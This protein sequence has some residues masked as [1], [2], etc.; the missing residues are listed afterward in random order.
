MAFLAN[1]ANFTA[2]SAPANAGAAFA[3]AHLPLITDAVLAPVFV[4]LLPVVM[5][6]ELIID[7][8]NCI[9]I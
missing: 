3:C 5:V 1:L 8:K 9:T 4:I 6:K 7:S 2:N